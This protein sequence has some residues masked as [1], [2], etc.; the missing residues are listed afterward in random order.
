VVVTGGGAGI[1]AAVA[2]ELGRRG[3]HVVT[4]DPLM[5]LDGTEALPPP[6]ETTAGRIV[7]SG[8]SARASSASVTD[9]AAVAELFAGLLAEF[10]RLDA[11]VNVAGISRP[12]SF[13]GG[14]DQDWADVLSVHL[15]GHLN[16]LSAALPIMAEAGHGRVLGVTSGSGWR[17]ADT[18]AYGCAKRAVASLTWQLGPQVPPGVVV[19]AM[20]P[21]AM[22][23]MVTAALGRRA[24]AQGSSGPAPS[25]GIAMA[26]MPDPD[27]LGPTA[28]YLLDDASAWT[29]G[30]VVFAGGSEVAIVDGP[31]LVEAVRT[32]DVA[33][34]G[35]VLDAVTRDALGPAEA[36]QASTGGSAPRFAG[37]FDGSAA[38]EGASG[39]GRSCVVV[40]GDRALAGSV[41]AALAARGV[42]A[43]VVR[44]P[45]PGAGFAGAAASLASV[46]EA[47]GPIDAVAVLPVVSRP[48]GAT[49]E[50]WETTL[51]EHAG[52]VGDIRSDAGWARAVADLAATTG[53]SVRLVTLVDACTAGGRSRAQA[54]AQLSRAASGATAGRVAAVAVAVETPVPGAEPTLAEVIAHLVGD[55]DAGALSGAELVVGPGWFGLRSHPR[56]GGSVTFGGPAVPE[57][58][59][60]ALREIAG[61][62]PAGT[63]A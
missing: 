17:M 27:R 15:G 55:P 56:P 3:D 59:D 61:A 37:L 25:G 36:A 22:T 23:R 10:G 60:G 14:A 8:G 24:P 13:A 47:A 43:H 33:D 58:L 11:V 26:S 9:G 41:T 39:P 34:V 29:R 44:A 57:W 42:T 5:S 48:A 35:A 50:G 30:R 7:A 54:A 53:R 4:L 31:R 21:I 52:L 32:A 62:A 40:D 1:G 12:T 49:G 28:A 6:E 20:S 46:V 45:E 38:R 19:N 51:A 63:G 18:G 2:E 16:V